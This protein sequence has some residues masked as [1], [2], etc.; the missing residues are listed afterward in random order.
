MRRNRRP[1]RR[2]WCDLGRIRSPQPPRDQPARR[3]GNAR[4]SCQDRQPGGDRRRCAALPVCT[5]GFARTPR[6]LIANRSVDGAR[7]L[8][9]RLE[10]DVIRSKK[11]SFTTGTQSHGEAGRCASREA[12]SS[13]FSV[14]LRHCVETGLPKNRAAQ[15]CHESAPTNRPPASPCDARMAELTRGRD[16]VH[17]FHPAARRKKTARRQNCFTAPNTAPARASSASA[18]PARSPAT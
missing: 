9:N 3:V 7:S 2:Y 16:R 10:L 12:Q 8:R 5:S 18:D 11:V 14:A 13:S 15:S 4:R 17:R 1:P 6:A